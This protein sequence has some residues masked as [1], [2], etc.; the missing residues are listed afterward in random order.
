M[1]EGPVSERNEPDNPAPQ[2]PAQPPQGTTSG[3]P[4]PGPGVL[5]P[6]KQART[7]GM[8][9]HLLALTG[10]IGIPFGNIIGPLVM[11]LMKKDDFAFVNDQGK[12][13]LNFQITMMIAGIVAALT[14][15]IV[16]GF[17]LLPAVLIV[18][19]VFVII[20]TL[21]ANEGQYYRYPFALRLIT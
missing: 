7:F 5:E 3:T 8:L 18:N 2:Q 21:K 6:D 17:I 20:A 12:E 11:W 13:A 9:C 4:S 14:V 16:I 19:L 15:F 1:A 10:F